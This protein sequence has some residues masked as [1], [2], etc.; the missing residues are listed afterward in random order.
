MPRKTTPVRLPLS[1]FKSVSFN[2]TKIQVVVQWT[3]LNPN[4]AF[5]RILYACRYFGDTLFVDYLTTGWQYGYRSI[6]GQ[7][8]ASPQPPSFK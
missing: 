7:V 5:D 6:V 4:W 2:K 1:I 3:F 8:L